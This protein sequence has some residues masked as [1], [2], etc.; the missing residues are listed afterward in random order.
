M[1][2]NVLSLQYS[3]SS[4]LSGITHSLT[5]SPEY[6]SALCRRAC[7]VI[8]IL[9][10]AP[11]ACVQHNKYGITNRCL[12]VAWLITG[13][14]M[15]RYCFARWRLSSSVGVCKTLHDRP[16][17]DFSRADQAMT[18]CRLQSNYSSTVTLHGGPVRLRR[19]RAT[20]CY[21]GVEKRTFQH[22][23]SS[24]YHTPTQLLC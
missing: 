1:S 10:A 8:Y 7:A 17:G 6:D 9:S 16:A 15:G 14:P 23:Q 4:A 22:G 3:Y 2:E 21:S 24:Y 19:V 11:A 18:S 12:D 5:E 20:P 13:R